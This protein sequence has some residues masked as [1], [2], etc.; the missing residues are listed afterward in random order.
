MFI[1]FHEICYF[2]LIK[3]DLQYIF[4]YYLNFQVYK[5]NY[6]FFFCEVTVHVM[7]N[8]FIYV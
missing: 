4:Q 8:K 2:S 5:Y 6:F 3:L 1:Q 7:L